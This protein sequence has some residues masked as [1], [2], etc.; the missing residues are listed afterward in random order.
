[1]NC[2]ADP[3]CPLPV[4]RDGMC[5]HHWYMFGDTP[6][7][8][9]AVARKPV[10]GLPAEPWYRSGPSEYFLKHS[11][12]DHKRHCLRC[13]RPL[14][15]DNTVGICGYCAMLWRANRQA[16]FGRERDTSP[17]AWLEWRRRH[18]LDAGE[19]TELEQP[20]RGAPCAACAGPRDGARGRMAISILCKRCGNK[21]RKVQSAL[22][23][24]G[25]VLWRI[26]DWAAKQRGGAVQ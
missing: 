16:A 24:R 11:T 17:A 4:H 22:A 10:I 25:R 8:Q 23:G 13:A 7:V 19:N 26:E 21:F 9:E 5:R 18:N 12:C 3:A 15:K 6:V 2:T 20:E 14:R 1:M